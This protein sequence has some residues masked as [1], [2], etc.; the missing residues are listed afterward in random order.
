[1]KQLRKI[2]TFLT[3]QKQGSFSQLCWQRVGTYKSDR[4]GLKLI[5]FLRDKIRFVIGEDDEGNIRV[6][7]GA[8]KQLDH[9]F[10]G[11][12]FLIMDENDYQSGNITF[13]KEVFD[14]QI[15]W[16]YEQGVME[17]TYFTSEK[18]LNFAKQICGDSLTITN[19]I[20]SEVYGKLWQVKVDFT[21]YLERKDNL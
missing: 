2:L 11:A 3:S 10:G 1:M 18:H 12:A 9:V 5:E 14:H 8:R 17:L 20:D 13:L 16:V 19:E 7:W 15:R 4:T 6:I 21:K